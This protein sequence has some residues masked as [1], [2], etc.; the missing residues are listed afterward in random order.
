MIGT[1]LYQRKS[2]VYFFLLLYGIL[3]I[4]GAVLTAQAVTQNEV[5]GN[6]AGFML[7]FGA[8]MCILTIVKG[9]KPQ[10]SFFADFL[11]IRQSRT[12]VLVRY[13]N[14]VSV[15]RKD[16]NRLVV[17]LREDKER[18]EVTIWL[19]ELGRDDIERLADFLINK[20][21]KTK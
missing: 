8:G 13:R 5:P 1:K 18:K 11:E 10:V 4:A 17:N 6:A 20:Q 2:R 12:P 16:M 15:S 14:I 9:R 3:A 21:W 19:R 7:V